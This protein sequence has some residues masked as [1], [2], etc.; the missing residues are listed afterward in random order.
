MKIKYFVCSDTYFLKDFV[1]PKNIRYCY[2]NTDPERKTPS[3]TFDFDV[4]T[5][6]DFYSRIKYYKLI[7]DD[8]GAPQKLCEADGVKIGDCDGWYGFN[9]LMKQQRH[10]HYFTI[11]HNDKEHNGYWNNLAD[12]AIA[13]QEWIHKVAEMAVVE[14]IIDSIE[15]EDWYKIEE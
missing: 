6:K 9:D 7:I 14:V 1:H 11:N 13:V 10:N 8:N 15:N 12:A 2:L 5:S 3:T 4:E